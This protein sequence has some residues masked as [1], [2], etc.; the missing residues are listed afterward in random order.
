MDSGYLFNTSV[1]NTLPT[2]ISK[3]ISTILLSHFQKT[4]CYMSIIFL[5]NMYP[6]KSIIFL[7]QTFSEK[8]P[9]LGVDIDMFG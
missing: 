9:L 6:K 5:S 3:A 4:L 1:I 8:L 7:K 2:C